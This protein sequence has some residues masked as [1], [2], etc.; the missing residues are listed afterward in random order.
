MFHMSILDLLMFAPTLI[1][2]ITLFGKKKEELHVPVEIPA[3]TGQSNDSGAGLDSSTQTSTP[4]PARSLQQ[5]DDKASRP[6]PEGSLNNLLQS[7]LNE[8]PA[9]ERNS[10][11]G[12]L[13]EQL[14]TPD[15]VPRR[16]TPPSRPMVLVPDDTGKR[17][18]QPV[19]T[20][21]QSVPT[22]PTSIPVTDFGQK[23]APPMTPGAVNRT[24]ISEPKKPERIE[25]SRKE[26]ELAWKTSLCISLSDAYI[27]QGSPC[28]FV[29]YDQPCSTLREKMKTLG[30]DPSPSESSYRLLMVDGFSAQSEV[31]SMEPYYV[32]KPL[33]LE[34]VQDV[35]SRNASIF[36]GEK[37]GIIL[38]SLDPV[39]SKI[40]A[41]EAI[42]KLTAMVAKMRELGATFVV[43]V[44]PDSLS[45]ELATSL[46][47]LADCVLDLEK[48]GSGGRLRVRKLKGAASK[49]KPEDFEIGSGKGMVFA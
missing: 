8:V 37:L 34:N 41:N 38:D 35:V 1:G 27:K 30:C 36:T 17:V 16:A 19:G 6:P 32:E 10:S 11:E 31:F 45:K 24:I 4:L 46:E 12:R 44:T 3:Q 23:Q 9:G 14:S 49:Q 48:S 20:Q 43:T 15:W 29:E 22:K 2:I 42:R 28:V 39:A 33:D 25:A 21:E 26:E 47:E 7:L 40:P 5:S 13:P 18:L